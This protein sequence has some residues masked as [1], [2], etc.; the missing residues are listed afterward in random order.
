MGSNFWEQ[1]RRSTQK[2]CLNLAKLNERWI[3]RA[4]R[5]SWILHQLNLPQCLR[6]TTLV[7]SRWLSPGNTIVEWIPTT[8]AI[9]SQPIHVLQ[10]TQQLGQLNYVHLFQVLELG[11]PKDLTWSYKT[12]S[13]VMNWKLDCN[14][15]LT[16]AWN[17]LSVS[18]NDNILKVVF[19]AGQV[20][21]V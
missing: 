12:T 18:P 14:C 21:T 1:Y 10:L 11:H 6:C 13:K 5:R 2:W 4:S 16:H 17:Q 7:L 20:H 19:V 9:S 15:F 8:L 3:Q